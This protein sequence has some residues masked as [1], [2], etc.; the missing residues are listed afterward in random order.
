MP[1]LSIR[2]NVAVA[3]AGRQDLLAEASRAVA[4]AL[5]KPERY[6]MVDL[7][8]GVSLRF[9]GEDGPA[10]ALV[11]DSIGLA[12][13]HASDL[14]ATLCAFVA[15]RMGVPSDRVYVRFASTPRT[16]WGWDGGTF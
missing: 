7:D 2:T 1:Y 6:V 3:E 4:A 11:L 15:A 14:S 13:D 10:A 5:G 12:P 16:M 8:A 9:A